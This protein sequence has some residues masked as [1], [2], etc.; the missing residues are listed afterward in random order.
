[1]ARYMPEPSQHDCFRAG[2][3]ARV[4]K[5]CEVCATILLSIAGILAAPDWYCT[6]FCLIR[7]MLKSSGSGFRQLASLRPRMEARP[8]IA[9]IGYQMRSPAQNTPIPPHL[10]MAKSDIA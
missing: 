4:G 6:L 3:A 5:K 7:K 8:G 10:A 1:M 2:T 9:A